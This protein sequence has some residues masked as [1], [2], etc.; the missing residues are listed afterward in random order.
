[1]SVSNNISSAIWTAL[2][3][4]AELPGMD[5]DVHLQYAKKLWKTTKLNPVYESTSIDM[6]HALGDVCWT[7]LMLVSAVISVG[8]IVALDEARGTDEHADP[9][10]YEKRWADAMGLSDLCQKLD[11]QMK[12]WDDWKGVDNE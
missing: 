12:Q 9:A 10:L 7:E 5:E 2:N 11:D 6:T 8:T 1:M 3:L 4:I